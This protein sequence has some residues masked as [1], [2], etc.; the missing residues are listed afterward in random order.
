ML[1]NEMSEA[2]I[3]IT[4]ESLR[5]INRKNWLV[6]PHFG[7]VRDE[8]PFDLMAW[9]EWPR[10]THMKSGLIAE[11]LS[12]GLSLGEAEEEICNWVCTHDDVPVGIEAVY[13]LAGFSVHFDRDF[14]RSRMP[15]LHKMFSHRLLDVSAFKIAARAWYGPRAGDV[16]AQEQIP[17]EVHRALPDCE[18][19]IRTLERIRGYIFRTPQQLDAKLRGHEAG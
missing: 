11:V 7:S 14:L 8:T 12:D 16:W 2:G 6:R 13:T 15:K 19:A 17:A 10:T 4:D 3:I 18:E 1:V 9:P 5:E